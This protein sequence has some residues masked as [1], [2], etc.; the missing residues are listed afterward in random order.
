MAEPVL[1]TKLAADSFWFPPCGNISW[2]G[3]RQ[4]SKS[5]GYND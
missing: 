1:A 4:R 5:N 3:K 2:K